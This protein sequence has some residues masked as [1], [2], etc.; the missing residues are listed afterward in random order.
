[1]RQTAVRESRIRRA[2]RHLDAQPVVEL[3]AVR[4]C[5][6]AR[7]RAEAS[8]SCEF[9]HQ[10]HSHESVGDTSVP[11]REGSRGASHDGGDRPR[12]AVEIDRSGEGV[13]RVVTCGR[14]GTESGV[15]VVPVELSERPASFGT[16]VEESFRDVMCHR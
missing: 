2:C 6:D 12:R 15:D 14:A 5:L 10:M 1:M 9:L 4:G 16:A 11:A 7:N 3:R 13:R 8:Q